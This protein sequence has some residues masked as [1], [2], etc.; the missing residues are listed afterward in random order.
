MAIFD[1]MYH[2]RGDPGTAFTAQHG[3]AGRVEPSWRWGGGQKGEKL[4]SSEGQFHWTM[5]SVSPPP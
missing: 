2:T 5:A 3:R 1:T 4:D